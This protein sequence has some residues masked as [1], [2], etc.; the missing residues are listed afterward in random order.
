VAEL[1]VEE[2]NDED[3]DGLEDLAPPLIRSTKWMEWEDGFR[4]GRLRF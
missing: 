4:R 3:E 1:V 2:S